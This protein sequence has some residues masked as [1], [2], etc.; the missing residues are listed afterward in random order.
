MQVHPRRNRKDNLTMGTSWKQFIH[1]MR[2]GM[3]S[4][5]WLGLLVAMFSPYA[6]MSSFSSKHFN[7]IPSC[8][9]APP[10]TSMLVDS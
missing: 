3:G 2:E 9:S 5:K 1:Y 8:I 4:P 10:P 7:N 6:G